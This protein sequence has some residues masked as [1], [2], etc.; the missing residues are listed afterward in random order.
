MLPGAGMRPS[1]ASLEPLAAKK[2]KHVVI[3]IQEN[4]SF[5]NLFY[6][7]PGAKTQSW[8]LD[9]KNKKITLQA[10]HTGDRMGHAAQRTSLHYLVRWYRENPRH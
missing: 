9:S 3:I 2:I 5:N 10:H 7:Y 6:G 8:G 4:R 1:Q